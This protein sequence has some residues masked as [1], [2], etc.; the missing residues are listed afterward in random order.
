MNQRSY[1]NHPDHFAMYEENLHQRL[2]KKNLTSVKVTY[3]Q[4]FVCKI[5]DQDK[6]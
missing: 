1:L 6:A 4:Y 2:R 3:K 5:G